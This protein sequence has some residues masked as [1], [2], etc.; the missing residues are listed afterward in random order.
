M[1]KL[2]ALL[3]I[4]VLAASVAATPATAAGKAKKVTLYLHGTYPLGEIDGVDW[5]ANGT[6]PMAMTKDEPTEQIPRS[7]VFGVP[8]LNTQCS[9]LPLG[10][11]T[12]VGVITGTITGDAILTINTVSAPLNLTARLWVNTPVFSCNDAYIPPNSEVITEIPAGQGEV[13]IKFPKLRLK[14]QG[15]IMIELVGTGVPRGRVLY[16][17]PSAAS[18]LTFNCVCKG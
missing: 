5:F 2:I 16:D 13:K 17:S 18:A 3:T 8:G 6:P 4:T 10:F 1:R 14:A 9:G 12:W 15:L 11:P 7:M